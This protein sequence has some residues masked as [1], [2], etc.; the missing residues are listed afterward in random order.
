MDSVY[1]FRSLSVVEVP[2]HRRVTSCF[3]LHFGFIALRSVG[4]IAELSRS[5]EVPETLKC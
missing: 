3:F 5:T 2:K 4:R 1:S